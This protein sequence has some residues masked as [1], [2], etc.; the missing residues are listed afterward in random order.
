[1]NL[2]LGLVTGVANVVNSDPVR[3]PSTTD[4]VIVQKNHRDRFYIM[5][6]ITLIM[7]KWIAGE[8]EVAPDQNNI[9]QTQVLD[10]SSTQQLQNLALIYCD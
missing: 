1:M 3:D 5:V 10:P 6:M 9:I 8:F 4:I 2:G 7:N